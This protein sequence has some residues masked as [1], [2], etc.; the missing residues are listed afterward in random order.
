M[1][2]KLTHINKQGNAKMVDVSKKKVTAR[3]AKA[4]IE[5]HM[6]KGTLK[7]IKEGGSKKGDV[8]AVATVA[9]IQAAKHTFEL[10]PMCHQIP[11]T[12]V[13]IEY[14]YKTY[15]ILVKSEVKTQY[16]TGVEMEALTAV[17][18]AAL[19]IYDMVKAIDKKVYFSN[20]K[21]NYKNGGK[22]GE[23]KND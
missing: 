23:F 3:T 16:K 2:K 10:I 9:G 20:A 12:G 11:L 19:T 1:A 14:E 4:S 13:D 5:V 7:R 22:S 6:A 15:G 21:L 8:L 17:N 18:V